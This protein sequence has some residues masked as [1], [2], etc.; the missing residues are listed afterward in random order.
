MPVNIDNIEKPKHGRQ[1]KN[2]TKE[3][4]AQ[5]EGVT[6]L[7]KDENLAKNK[8]E[9]ARYDIKIN[10]NQHPDVAILISTTASLRDDRLDT[11]NSC[12]LRCKRRYAENDK[13]CICIVTS[14]CDSER[15]P[16]DDKVFFD[17][18]NFGDR[19][20]VGIDVLIKTEDLAGVLN[21][22]AAVVD[23]ND[24]LKMIA[25]AKDY[26]KTLNY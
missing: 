3:L 24:V 14:P 13:Q 7:K 22:M 20:D 19:E 10:I 16:G 26:I 18:Y 23:K 4:I 8:V 17:A 2:Q 1:S 12:M 11:A 6:I 5:S 9:I 15:N 21:A 25:A